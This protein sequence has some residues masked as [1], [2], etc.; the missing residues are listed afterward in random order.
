MTAGKR[1]LLFHS[2]AFY[3]PGPTNLSNEGWN[4][5]ILEERHEAQINEGKVKIKGRSGQTLN[6]ERGGLIDTCILQEYN[7][8][9]FSCMYS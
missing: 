8:C 4:I 5:A 2:S 3:L 6:A 9:Q 7:V 1:D